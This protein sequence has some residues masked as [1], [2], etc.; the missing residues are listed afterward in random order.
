MKTQHQ[1][2]DSSAP[3]QKKDQRLKIVVNAHPEKEQ[4]LFSFLNNRR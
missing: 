2:L 4:K 3:G 1:K